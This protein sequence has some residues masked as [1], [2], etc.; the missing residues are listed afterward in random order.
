MNT[1]EV[2]WP[3]AI[4][5]GL[6]AGLILLQPDLGTAVLLVLHGRA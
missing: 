6:L 2:L 5:T 1:R 3:A 4:V